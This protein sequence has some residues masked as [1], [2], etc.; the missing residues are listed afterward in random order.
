[1]SENIV[2][3]YPLTSLQRGML[4]EALA[5]PE[6]DINVAY[7]SFDVSGF[8]DREQLETAWNKTV[9]RYAALRTVF[10]W[11]GLEKPLQVVV[12][13]CSLNIEFIEDGVDPA[14]QGIVST[15]GC[16]TSTRD[17][18]VNDAIRTLKKVGFNLQSAPLMKLQLIQWSE[19]EYTMVW[20]IHH[21]LADAWSAPLIVQ[22]MM[23][24]YDS[25]ESSNVFDSS[26]TDSANDNFNFS[27]YIQ[28]IESLDRVAIKE[29][30]QQYLKN[31]RYTRFNLVESTQGS[32]AGKVSQSDTDGGLRDYVVSQL[33]LDLEQ[34]LNR[35][36]AEQSITTG[37]FF[38]AV[39]AVVTAAYSDTTKPLFGTLFS[40]RYQSLP[41]INEAVGPFVNTLP[42]SISLSDK[43]STFDWIRQLQSN[44]QEN[45][46]YETV[47]LLDIK[48][49]YSDDN[50][51]SPFFSVL[52]IEPESA[53]DECVNK[54]GS[55]RL[56]NF[57]YQVDSSIPLTLMIFN[58]GIT[59]FRLEY[60]SQCFPFDTIAR[61]QSDVRFVIESVL[62]NGADSP[63]EQLNRLLRRNLVRSNSL[64]HCKN[65]NANSGDVHTTVD[66]WFRETAALAADRHA[67]VHANGSVSYSELQDSISVLSSRLLD[68]GTQNNKFVAICVSH[69]ADQIISMFGV[70]ESGRA[71]LV[72][73]A[74]SPC[75][76]LQLLLGQS[77]CQIAIVDDITKEKFKRLS[78]QLI[79]F[80]NPSSKTE[81]K[82]QPNQ[83]INADDGFD[84]AKNL[85]YDIQ[86]RAAADDL[87]YVL[88]TSGST[89]TPKGVKISHENLIYS[90]W[91]RLEYYQVQQPCFILV[92]PTTFD[93]SVAGIYWSLL[94]GGKLILPETDEIRDIHRIADLASATHTSRLA[95]SPPDLSSSRVPSSASKK[96]S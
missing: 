79:D 15:S 96:S 17:S 44:L 75:D 66:Q 27:N 50:E 63:L 7:V 10:M 73:D 74:D 93:S 6:S 18:V 95:L 25:V 31:A 76:R 30:W 14:D 82:P 49:I 8:I 65:W 71:Y 4:F 59:N 21:L 47:D 42:V 58:T 13:E 70:L 40:G 23:D 35:V 36:C 94:G 29:H 3:A 19:S 69:V 52:V 2:D 43:Q 51:G 1:M 5:A 24:Y 64:E 56:R 81:S 28:H 91:A 88:Y 61:I 54:E 37:T 77:R 9:S 39:W 20:A 11:D 72:I 84:R 53:Y 38:H 26:P 80:D 33:P 12:N 48:S 89:G 60:D 68:R 86:N 67:L 85:D 83:N 16:S 92:S 32:S 22:T 46:Q 90:T 55:I 87:V 45:Q 57:S 62:S 41:G 34:Q 78:I